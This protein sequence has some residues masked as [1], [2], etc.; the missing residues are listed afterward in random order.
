VDIVVELVGIPEA[1]VGMLLA[2]VGMLVGNLL[3]IHTVEGTVVV[4]SIVVVVGEVDS[5]LGPGG[6]VVQGTVVVV[7]VDSSH[8]LI[9]EGDSRL[10]A[11]VSWDILW[12]QIV[13]V[14]VL[15]SQIQHRSENEHLHSCHHAKLFQS[16]IAEV[17]IL[18][19]I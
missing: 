16:K 19:E 4:V 6:M 2:V 13:A 10:I 14:V 9:G 1:V 8:R 5:L 11:V 15:A 12:L 3:V 17:E 7:V 18:F